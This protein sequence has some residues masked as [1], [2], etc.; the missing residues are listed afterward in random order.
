MKPFCL[1][2]R[3]E[4]PDF[5]G[6][7]QQVR[8]PVPH[9]NWFSLH[10]P[11]RKGRWVN[12]RFFLSRTLVERFEQKTNAVTETLNELNGNWDETF[13]RFMAR[14]FGFKI[15]ALPFELFAK[16]VP[17]HIYA[18]HKNNPHQIEALVL[19]LQAFKWSFWR[20]IPA[21]VKSRISVSPKEI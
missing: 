2:F 12:R 1:A 8:K 11:D 10:F 6:S 17:Q 13:Y 21:E 14:N 9:L 19:V 5:K 16:A 4:E 15:N 7:D 20:R 3:T 18:R